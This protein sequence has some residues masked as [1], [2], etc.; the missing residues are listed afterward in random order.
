MWLTDDGI[1]SPHFRGKWDGGTPVAAALCPY[2]KPLLNRTPVLLLFLLVKMFFFKK[3]RFCHICHENEMA[4]IWEEWQ[5]L[6][7]KL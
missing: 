3:K 2:L 1:P 7:T 5:Q 4:S 6:L